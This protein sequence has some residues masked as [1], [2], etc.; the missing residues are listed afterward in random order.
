VAR[1]AFL[2]A[3]GRHLVVTVDGTRLGLLKDDLSLGVAIF[4]RDIKV[5]VK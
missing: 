4:T 3:G 5:T 1:S 2:A